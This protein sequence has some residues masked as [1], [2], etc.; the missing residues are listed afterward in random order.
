MMVE[1]LCA[2]MDCWEEGYEVVP[3]WTNIVMTPPKTERLPGIIHAHSC[4]KYISYNQG[5]GGRK[6][7]NIGWGLSNCV[8]TTDL[9]N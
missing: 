7:K 3:F 4:F 5:G 2:K 8:K 9:T 1:N 6:L